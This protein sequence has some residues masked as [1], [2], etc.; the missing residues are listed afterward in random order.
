[1]KLK[2]IFSVY[3]IHEAKAKNKLQQDKTLL[4]A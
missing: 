3:R 2:K 4:G 1:M